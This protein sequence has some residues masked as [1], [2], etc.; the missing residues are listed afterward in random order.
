MG[1]FIDSIDEAVNESPIGRFFDLK[2]RGSKLSIEFRGALATFMS[3]AYIL[4]VNPRIISDSGGPCPF[5]ESGNLF[6]PEYS[7]CIEGVKKELITSTALAS[8]FGC[9]AMGLG[10]NLPVALAPGMGMNAYFTYSV[11]GFR[12][13]GNISY[14][15]ACTAVLI[16]GFIFLFLAVTGIRYWIIKFI[17]EPVR[18]ATPAAI[19]AFLA[20]LGLQTAEGI[21]LV[22]SDIATAV[23]LG[24][25]PLSKRTPIVA[26]TPDCAANTNFCVTSDAY[27]CDDEGGV[28]TSAMTWLGLLG[29]AIM[30]ILL[31]YRWRSA[32]IVGIS[33]VTFISWFRDTAVTYFPND[34]IGDARFEYFKQVVS[35]EPLDK[36]LAPFTNELSDAGVA[37]FTF[38]YVDFLDTSG[39]LLGIVSAMGYVNEEGDFPKSYFAY[40]A[41]ALATI[42]GSIFGLSPVT[43]YI[44]SGSGVEAGSR[45]GL[46]AVFCGFFFFLS[47]FFA[48]IIAS[49]PAWAIGGALIIVGSLVARSLAKVKWYD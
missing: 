19:G 30:L 1:A 42:F 33:F 2:E 4:A 36:V 32:F 10:A 37:L 20:H 38:L 9:F 34:D 40:S 39:T 48:P 35:I 46:T 14:E 23:T 22:V 17:P 27:T 49:I 16:E 26:L 47:L 15:S 31:A 25:C 13:T 7:A 5:P 45:T 8:M 44:E 41:D 28:M 21:G 24:A 29:M 43:S 11:V 12:G 18:L 3:M 6:E